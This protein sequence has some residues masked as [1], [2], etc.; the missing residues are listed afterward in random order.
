MAHALTSPPPAQSGH[1]E[2]MIQGCD[3]AFGLE[4]T[5]RE[6]AG[7]TAGSLVFVHHRADICRRCF[8]HPL[9]HA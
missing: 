4:L 5:S 9:R 3:P 2:G 8:R 1:V 6:K 7:G